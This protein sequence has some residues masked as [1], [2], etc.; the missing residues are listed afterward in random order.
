[1]SMRRMP[2]CIFIFRDI[3]RCSAFVVSSWDAECTRFKVKCS[4][5]CH[6]SEKL[7]R[8]QV[9]RMGANALVLR[10]LLKDTRLQSLPRLHFRTVH[11]SA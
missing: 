6:K 8:T 3:R 1:M 4:S 9:L 5:S 2:S 10:R 7:E 11:W